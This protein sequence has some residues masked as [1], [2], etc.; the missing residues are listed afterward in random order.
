MSQRWA[1]LEG[2]STLGNSITTDIKDLLTGCS[3]TTPPKAELPLFTT[4]TSVD[5][6]G[7][8][9]K[10]LVRTG[11]L[12]DGSAIQIALSNDGG[13]TWNLNY[14]ATASLYGGSAVI[15]AQA[16]TVLWSTSASGVQV[17]QYTSSFTQVSSLPS[18]AAV[19]SDK[20]NTTV[21]YGGS[22]GSFYRSTDTGKTFTTTTKL[23]SSTAVN[24]I[25][26]NPTVAGDVWVTTDKGLFHSTNYGT[27]FSAITGPTAGWSLA[28]GKSTANTYKYNI[29]GF[30]TINGVSTIFESKD[31]GATWTAISDSAHGFGSASSNPVAASQDTEGLV[32][33]GTNGRGVFYGTP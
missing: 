27:T 21:F 26:A 33:V 11:N 17:S 23:G 24:K 13:A 1:I 32:Y 7:K 22:G 29:F 28:L 8:V 12:A 5:Y 4:S 19:A 30:F 15:N 25:A 18:G 31:V 20:A 9:P 6:A 3:L 2:S 10:S 14:G 16:D